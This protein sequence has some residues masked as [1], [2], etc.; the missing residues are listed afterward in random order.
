M[1]PHKNRGHRWVARLKFSISTDNLAI[2]GV[3]CLNFFNLWVLRVVL[4]GTFGAISK[5]RLANSD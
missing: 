5:N 4:K 3:R 1:S 2:V